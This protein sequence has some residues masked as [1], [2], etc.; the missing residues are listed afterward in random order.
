M[1][2]RIGFRAR[3]GSP[4]E[5]LINQGVSYVVLDPRFGAGKLQQRFGARARAGGREG[6]AAAA[7][8]AVYRRSA[9]FLR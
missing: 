4:R 2:S 8:H 6:T 1:A 9:A 7:T 3:A 5:I